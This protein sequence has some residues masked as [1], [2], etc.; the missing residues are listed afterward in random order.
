MFKVLLRLIG[1]SSKQPD[2]KNTKPTPKQSLREIE[3]DLESLTRKF[4]RVKRMGD[5]LK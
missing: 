3:K 2:Q 1:L 5:S 4:S